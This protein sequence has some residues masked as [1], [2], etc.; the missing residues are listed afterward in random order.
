MTTYLVRATNYCKLSKRERNLMSVSLG[1][2]AALVR[3]SFLVQSIYTEVAEK[4]GLTA[5]H[6]QLICVVREVPRGMSELAGLLR[7]E[8]SS[9]SGLV[10]RAE[11]RGLLSRRPENDDRRATSVKLTGIGLQLADAFHDEVTQKLAAVVSALSTR[12]EQRFAALASRVLV[13]AGIPVIFADVNTPD[14]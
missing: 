10:D 5:A 1:S 3:L 14:K 9:L 7:L 11:Q 12:E 8:K 4:H 13:S 2:A 6:A